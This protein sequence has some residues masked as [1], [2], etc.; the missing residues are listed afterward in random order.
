MPKYTRQQVRQTLNKRIDSFQL[1]YR[2]NIGILGNAGL[3]KTKLLHQVYNAYSKE[4]QVICA[5]LQADSLDFQQLVD[6]WMGSLLTAYLRY[7]KK[8]IE[9]PNDCN[10]LIESCEMDLPKTTKLMKGILKQLQRRK[11]EGLVEAL[12][13]LTQVMYQETGRDILLIIDEFQHLEKL[14]ANDPFALLGKEI[15][16]QTHTFY[17]VASSKK[18]HAKEI[19]REKLSL[20]FGNFE[21]V[22]LRAFGFEETQDYLNSHFPKTKFTEYQKQLLIVLTDGEPLYLDLICDRLKFYISPVADQMISDPLIF[23]TL[24]EELYNFKGRIHLL[25]EN[26]LQSAVRNARDVSACLKTLIC[27]SKGKH[28]LS[29]ISASIGR[30]KNETKRFLQK[31]IQEDCVN[32]RGD[33]FLIEDSLFCFWLS[34]VFDRKSHSYAPSDKRASEELYSSLQ[35]VMEKVNHH[36]KLSMTARIEKVIREFRGDTLEWEEIKCKFPQFTEVLHRQ[37]SGRFDGLEAKN[38]KCRWICQIANQK[39]QEEDVLNFM[40]DLKRLKKRVH[41]KVIFCLQGVEQNAR[42]MAQDSKI[43]LYGVRDINLFL[44]VHNLPQIIT[45]SEELHIENEITAERISV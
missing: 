16:V 39:V 41:A 28:K 15:M 36:A 19:F 21:V 45:L 24:Q 8:S 42:L 5:F 3:G 32:K 2:Q 13:S 9:G 18:E 25:F 27:I 11:F 40:S 17:L 30:T 37:T 1:G 12:F 22:E 14:P 33:F 7:R 6:I 23:L 35:E 38:E 26:R 43:K 34:E 20:L 10:V 4:N 29:E 44:R 31:L